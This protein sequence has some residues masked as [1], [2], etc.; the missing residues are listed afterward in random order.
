MGIE[1]FVETQIC[2]LCVILLWCISP[3]LSRT[4]LNN[5]VET[6]KCGVNSTVDRGTPDVKPITVATTT[7]GGHNLDQQVFIVSRPRVIAAQPSVLGRNDASPT[8]SGG[9]SCTR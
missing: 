4:A 8:I 6:K 9:G 5:V 1:D 2:K 7:P 3:L